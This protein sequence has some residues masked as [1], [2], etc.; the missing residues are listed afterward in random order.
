MNILVYADV[1][2][3][4]GDESCFSDPTQT[5]QHYRVRKF[6]EDLEAIYKLHNCKGVIDLGDTSNDRSSIPVPTI[7]VLGTGLSKIP[8]SDWNFKLTGNHEQYFRNA[9]VNNRRLFE[10]KFNVIDTRA[11]FNF[12]KF[13]AFFVSYTND[14]ADLAQWITE[15]VNEHLDAPKILFGHI[16]LVGA[17]LSGGTSVAGLSV[18]I[19]KPFNLCLLGHFHIP[20]TIGSCIH[21]VG[22]PF[23][24]NW[25]ECGE[26]KRVGI[27]DTSKL[28]ITW[29][30]LNGYPRYIQLSLEEFK[31]AASKPSEH[32]YR[33]VLKNHAE[34]EEFFKHPESRRAQPVYTYD[35]AEI[36]AACDKQD[37]S[38]EG[39]LKRWLEVAPPKSVGIDASEQELI[40]LAT[41]I[42]NETI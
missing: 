17:Q 10:G 29:V 38:F 9:E 31:K 4:D 11:I 19:L 32:R 23:Q 6:F 35:Q 27:L 25:G 39:T 34:S 2:A 40:E 20:Q 1:H 15:G 13:M 33:V 24:Q 7:E 28:T 30:Q 42:A 22:S 16:D 3:T 14:Y 8:K 41:S 37:W 12:G 36:E 18:D 21:Y 5:L 26:E